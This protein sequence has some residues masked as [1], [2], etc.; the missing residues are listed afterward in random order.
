MRGFAIMLEFECPTRPGLLVLFS[1]VNGV[2]NISALA[3]IKPPFFHDQ[4]TRAN[5][6]CAWHAII[7]ARIINHLSVICA[8]C[9]SSGGEE[10]SS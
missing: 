9:G 1:L 8:I 5:A 4:G 3:S 2:A 10:E 6:E 7:S